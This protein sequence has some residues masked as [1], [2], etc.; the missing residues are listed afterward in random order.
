MRE[1]PES[2]KEYFEEVEIEPITK[3][4]ESAEYRHKEQKSQNKDRM[5]QKVL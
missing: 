3:L 2:A 4:L 5:A 1:G